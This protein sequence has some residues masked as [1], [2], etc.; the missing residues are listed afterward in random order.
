MVREVG[1][2]YYD[3]SQVENGAADGA[4]AKSGETCSY[5]S[6]LVGMKDCNWANLQWDF[7]HSI[8]LAEGTSREGDVPLV[9]KHLDLAQN[10]TKQFRYGKEFSHVFVSETIDRCVSLQNEEVGDNDSFPR[11]ECLPKAS[12]MPVIRSDLKFAAHGHKF[13]FLGNLVSELIY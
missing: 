6:S 4:Y 5:Y 9:E 12:L 10:I 2:S 3:P 8:D 13:F 7:A 1:D 11:L